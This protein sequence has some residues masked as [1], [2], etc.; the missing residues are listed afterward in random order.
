MTS[1][2][3]TQIGSDYNGRVKWSGIVKGSDN[4]FYCLPF[5]ARQILKID[6]SNDRITLVGEEYDGYRKWC[7][8]FAHG[9]FVYGIP[10]KANQFLKYNTKTE[11]S[12]LV[13]DDLGNRYAEWMSGAVADDGCLYC[14]PYH[15]HRILKLNLNDDT[16]IF[17]GEEMEI[18]CNFCGTI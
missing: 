13:G 11:T 4:C 7:T 17:V 1:I 3:T 14:F 2:I 16:T 9:N 12:V 15:H 10:F 6:P 18:G 8:G 5:S